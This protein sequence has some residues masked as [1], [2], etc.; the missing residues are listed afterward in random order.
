MKK[1]IGKVGAHSAALAALKPLQYDPMEKTQIMAG[2]G[3][4][5]S[6]NAYAL[7]IVV[8]ANQD[9]M[10]NSGVSYSKGSSAMINAGLSMRVGHR[11]MSEANE[12]L[13][14]GPIT[15]M[16]RMADELNSVKAENKELREEMDTLKKQV[17]ELLA[18]NA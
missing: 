16:Y 1:D 13:K 18:K 15:A 3:H 11:D 5:K 7:G 2:V 6:E 12:M 10:F 4:Y 8:H 17:Q 14:D 9:F